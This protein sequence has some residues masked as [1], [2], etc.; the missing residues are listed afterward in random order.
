M[1][2]FEIG[3]QLAATNDFQ[4]NLFHLGN[5]QLCCVKISFNMTNYSSN[6]FNI[7]GNKRDVFK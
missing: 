7:T 5:G 1:V 3:A 6:W 2:T 4:G